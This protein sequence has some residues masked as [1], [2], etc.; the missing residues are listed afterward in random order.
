MF[1]I[2]PLQAIPLVK[3][4]DSLKRLIFT[5]KGN[6]K[7]TDTATINHLNKLAESYY[8]SAPDST[9]YFA[10]LAKKSS[11]ALGY[12]TGIADA[13]IQLGDVHSFKGEYLE[14]NLNYTAA[15]NLYQ[16]TK[17]DLGISNA[18]M[19][20][21]R[22]QDFVGNYAKAISYFQKALNI[23]KRLNNQIEIANCHAIIGITYDNMGDFNNALDHYFKSLLIDI[24]LN[25]Q[26]A[27]ADNYC[28]IG[29]V[30][31]HLE[32]YSKAIEYFNKA[33]KLWLKLDD[34]QGISTIYQNIGEVYLAQKKLKQ[35]FDNF[36]QA[37]V[38]YHQLGDEEGI[39]LI[40]YNFGLYY[41]QTGQIDSAIYYL[42]KSL[43]SATQN[44]IQYN[45]ACAQT[46]LAL[47][48]NTEKKYF[49][50]LKYATLA[51]KTAGNLQSIN[52]KADA[53]EQL[54]KAY[55][56]LKDYQRA[57]T[58]HLRF[59]NLKDSLN[60]S[61]SLQK[62]TSYNTALQF[63]NAQQ[64][65]SK[66]EAQLFKKLQQQRR[67]S[68]IY[69]A[70]I[71]V[72]SLMLLFYYNAKRKQ[73]KA[74]SLLKDRNKKIELQTEK[75]NELNHLKDRLISI[76]AH[77]LRAPLSTLRG[78]F[79]LIMD[80]DISHAE[81]IKMV[82]VVFSKLEHT[83]DFLDTLL[84]W[85]NSQ[86]DNIEETTKSFC[87]H[88]VVN[89]ELYI[90]NEQ[91]KRKRITATNKVDPEYIVLG[92][93]KSIRIVIHNFLTNAI[94]FSHPDNSVDITAVKVN[95]RINFSITDHGIG[96]SPD[97]LNSLFIG[98]VTSRSGTMNE[99]G[100]GM[101]LIFCKDLIEKYNGKIWAKSQPGQYTEFGFSLEAGIHT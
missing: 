34:K 55:A 22:V 88:D 17:K 65:A 62:L 40:Y 45:K 84:F 6:L 4:T 9:V 89:E 94:K 49:K 78:A 72:I 24:K 69:T 92:D 80:D 51:L 36:K 27:A 97:Q 96:M 93:P 87:L 32:L 101:G 37:S 39:S 82:P 66:K 2:T 77:D 19:G 79:T 48:Y 44:Q 81:F 46:G 54:S 11:Q 26:L 83:S 95:G 33:N 23:R 25:D 98:K 42:N 68:I 16:V 85:I 63:E 64:A 91:F 61:E 60:H 50:A 14:A 10:S 43:V 3:E 7:T 76:L 8:E 28:N 5:S 18:L 67:A 38:M 73:L 71:V 74:N 90:L 52:L 99:S 75:L 53:T 100:T 12:K 15:L 41:N 56:G 47:V 13:D 70:I 20:L 21:G 57:F 31:Q 1:L 58:A 59:V 86:V 30:M 35:A 29:V